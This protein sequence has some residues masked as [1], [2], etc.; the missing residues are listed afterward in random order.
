MFSTSSRSHLGKAEEEPEAA[1]GPQTGLHGAQQL[2][3]ARFTTTGRA[4]QTAVLTLGTTRL[5]ENGT[6]HT[7][8]GGCCNRP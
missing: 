1:A 8:E 6:G 5:P 7:S 3:V 4:G 2:G